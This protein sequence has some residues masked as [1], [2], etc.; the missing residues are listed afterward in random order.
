MRA[1][2]PEQARRDSNPQ[3]PVLE[4]GA[5]P[6]ELRTSARAS[7]R[8]LVSLFHGQGRNRT[9]DT[10]IFSRVLYQL[11]YLAEKTPGRVIGSGGILKRNFRVS[12]QQ[13]RLAIPPSLDHVS[14]VVNPR[15]SA[16]S[17]LWTPTFAIKGI[18]MARS[19]LQSDRSANPAQQGKR[20]PRRR[21]N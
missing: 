5:L 15:A 20:R 9:A 12:T 7:Q 17:E 1:N 19:T 2:C 8:P 6:I 13:W 16:E 14:A 18:R 10:T 4:T 21:S 3:P 11:S